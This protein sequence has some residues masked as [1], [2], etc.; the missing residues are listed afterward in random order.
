MIIL[1]TAGLNMLTLK[2]NNTGLS[3]FKSFDTSKITAVRNGRETQISVHEIVKGD[4]VKVKQGDTV[5][6]DIRV[7]KTS[8]NGVIIDNSILTNENGP[9]YIGTEPGE[10]GISNPL[11]SLNML[12]YATKCIDGE[13]LGV[14]I[15][16]ANNTLIGKVSQL[17]QSAENKES[18]FIGEYRS[19]IKMMATIAI[20]IAILF[21]AFGFLANFSLMTNFLNISGIIVANTPISLGLSLLVI[22]LIFRKKLQKRGTQVKTL[23]SVE[24][25]GSTTCICTDKT[26]IL[27]EN[28]MNVVYLWYDMEFKTINKAKENIEIM[29]DKEQI[30][31]AR[32][33]PKD[34]SFE[35]IRMTAVCSSFGDIYDDSFIPEN[36]P[37]FVER[38]KKYI[39]ENK[40]SL[41]KD[42]L[43]V[44]IQRIE[45]ELLPSYMAYY[46]EHFQRNKKEADFIDSGILRFFNPI[47]SV[48]D[49]RQTYQDTGFVFNS[50]KLALS[51]RKVSQGGTI[52][53]TVVIKGTIEMVVARC[54]RFIIKGKEYPVSKKFKEHILRAQKYFQLNGK[55]V[56]ALAFLDLSAEQYREDYEFNVWVEKRGN[57]DEIKANFPLKNYVFTSLLALEDLPK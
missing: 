57:N 28:K 3:S 39:L 15:N 8:P 54:S 31:T 25:I 19:F 56:I 5:P 49:T 2:L 22:F 6:A 21:F 46:K 35:K 27:T 51:I 4:V 38:K 23:H 9:K 24:A 7:F 13:A 29:I 33:H 1:I 53:L 41:T 55:R 48:E 34:K 18:A 30:V 16:T 20:P 52:S 36:Y 10:K 32:F 11:A 43:L 37:E 42:E 12:F 44:G 17:T 47:E 40:D 45:D 50:P 14:V 26:A